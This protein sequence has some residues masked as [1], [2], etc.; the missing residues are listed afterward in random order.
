[1]LLHLDLIYKNNPISHNVE[2]KA[3]LESL[4]EYVKMC[5]YDEHWLYNARGWPT[6][7]YFTYMNCS[8]SLEE[9]T[10]NCSKNKQTSKLINKRLHWHKLLLCETL[11]HAS[12]F[13]LLMPS[14][15]NPTLKIYV[16]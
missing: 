5:I 13:A 12:Y 7:P 10:I 1:M 14:I 6:G 3:D 16:M 8:C 2:T 15:Y 4:H 11:A 9:H